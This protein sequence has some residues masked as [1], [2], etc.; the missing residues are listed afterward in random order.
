MPSGAHFVASLDAARPRSR[1]IHASSQRSLL[2]C[3]GHAFSLPHKSAHA[4]SQ[5][6]REIVLLLTDDDWFRCAAF[7]S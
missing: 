1:V 2:A 3:H 5:E 7:L 6:Q 4:S